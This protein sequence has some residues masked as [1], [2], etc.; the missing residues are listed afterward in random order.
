MAQA[1]A[2]DTAPAACLDR[3]RREVIDPGLCVACGACLGLCPH[4]LFYDGQVAAPDPCGRVEGR[5]VDLCPQ[6]PHPDPEARRREV[7]AGRGLAADAPLGAVRQAW[8]ARATAADLAGRAQYGGVVSALASLAL[9]QGLINEAVLTQT[10]QRGAPEGVRVRDR[11]GVLGCAGS[12]YAAAGSL[13]ALNQALAETAGHPLGVV[14][15]PCQSL[16]A[17]SM[18]THPLYP[19]AAQRLKLIIGLFCTM[20]LSARGLRGVLAEAG[21]EGAVTRS[22]FPPPPAGV[23]VVSTRRGASEIPLERVRPITLP[24]CALCPDLTAEAADIAVGAAEGNPG[25]NTVIARSQTGLE[26]MELALA[27]GLIEV[28]PVPEES[29]AHLSTA[30]ANKRGRAQTALA[31]TAREA[32]HG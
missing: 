29:W 18:A 23:L 13:M 27:K 16:G 10:G 6:F 31:Q 7:L 15:L 24:G 22:D 19:A 25:F 9:E 8:W 20:N 1:Q 21:V 3:L 12:I 11:Q 28:R 4:L 30:A 2:A 14:A 32:H 5:C 17:L 26:L